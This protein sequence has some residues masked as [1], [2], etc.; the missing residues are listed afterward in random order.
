[1]NAGWQVTDVIE[2]GQ[3]GSPGRIQ[4]PRRLCQAHASRVKWSRL[5]GLKEYFYIVEFDAPAQ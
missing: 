5:V 1:V 4:N 2:C 3:H